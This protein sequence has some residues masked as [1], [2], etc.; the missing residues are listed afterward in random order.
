MALNWFDLIIVLFLLTFAWAGLRIG[1]VTLLFM[2]TGFFASLFA[3]GWLLPHV[4]PIHD[5]TLQTIVSGNLVLIVA[6]YMGFKG[7]DLGRELHWSVVRGYEPI[8]K[9]LGVVV[10]AS[11][12]LLLV[13]LGSTALAR[14]PFAGLSNSVSDALIVQ[15][16]DRHLPPVPA[17]FAEFDRLVNPN[18]PS[19]LVLETRPKSVSQTHPSLTSAGSEIAGAS[20]VRI[21]SFGCGGVVSG[22]GFVIAPDTVVTAAHVIAGVKRPIIKDNG[23]SLEGVPIYFNRNL[24]L[25]ALKVPGLHDRP[26]IISRDNIKDNTVVSAVGYPHGDYASTIG[27]VRDRQQLFGRNIYDIGLIKREVY[28]VQVDIDEGTSGGP[29]VLP[30]GQVI[31]ILFAKSQLVENYAY[32][33][34]TPSLIDEL[35]QIQHSIRRVNTGACLAN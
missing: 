22:S 4:L 34:T 31:G 30:D 16:L 5:H 17:V 18:S 12:A 6:L 9:I 27:V 28:E 13:W 23:R 21:T 15:S 29:V 32:A 33:L 11:G 25:A 20:T 26:L 10:S 19:H 8:E 1:F 3:A 7:F 2:L 24:D 14:L 35:T